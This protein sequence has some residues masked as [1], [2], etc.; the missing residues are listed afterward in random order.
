MTSPEFRAALK[1]LGLTQVKFCQAV[2]DLG[3]Q[4]LPL[5]TV[6]AWALGERPPHVLLAALVALM[7][8]DP[9]AW[10]R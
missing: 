3:G 2:A 8:R 7:E 4:P 5:R 1:R 9:Q 6:Q 10:K